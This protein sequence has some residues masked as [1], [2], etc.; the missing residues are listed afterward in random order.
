MSEHL[1]YVQEDKCLAVSP[2]HK[3]GQ[4]FPK[5]MYVITV[6]MAQ[7]GGGGGGGLKKQERRW[8]EVRKKIQEVGPKGITQVKLILFSM[9]VSL[10]HNWVCLSAHVCR[11]KGKREGEGVW[12]QCTLTNAALCLLW[13]T[14]ESVIWAADGNV[15]PNPQQEIT[16]ASQDL[17][18]TPNRRHALLL[19][20]SPLYGSRQIVPSK[21]ERWPEMKWNN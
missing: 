5:A 4:R 7:G 11:N 10:Y 13:D 2:I 14:P 3:E 6:N 18:G 21:E 8:Q 16:A 12:R 17:P 9:T 1:T 15:S 20:N 19:S